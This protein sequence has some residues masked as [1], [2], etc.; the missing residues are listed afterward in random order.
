[1]AG[2]T[3]DGSVVARTH[4]LKK[5]PGRA[6]LE[7]ERRRQ[8][9]EQRSLPLSETGG[10]FQK[11]FERRTRP[12]QFSKVGDRP[13]NLD[14]ESKRGRSR[15][16]PL[17]VRRRSVGT[18]KGGVDLRTGEDASVA[19]EMRALLSEPMRR[20]ARN[21]PS[22]GSDENTPG[23]V[24]PATHLAWCS[25]ARHVSTCRASR[26]P[27]LIGLWLR[28]ARSGC[29][30]LLGWRGVRFRRR[31]FCPRRSVLLLV[32][33]ETTLFV[34]AARAAPAWFVAAGA[35]VGLS[36]HDQSVDDCGAVYGL[37][38]GETGKA[39]PATD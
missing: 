16:S 24:S 10:F 31:G 14:C 19:L 27:R 29:R 17:R 11:R 21:R 12:P 7:R 20:R 28:R 18:M 33:R 5:C 37:T 26:F 23:H 38:H 3:D 1:M 4:E 22:C 9:H 6:R 2:L 30:R 36:G 32:L 25:R 15:R 13:W 35:D 8:L 39:V 34:F